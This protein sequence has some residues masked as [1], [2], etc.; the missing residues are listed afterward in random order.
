MSIGSIGLSETLHSY[1]LSVSVPTDPLWERLRDEI[2]WT[3][4]FNMQISPE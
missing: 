1:L 3:V 2:K 4:S